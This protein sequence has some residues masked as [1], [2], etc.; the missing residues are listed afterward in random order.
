[1]GDSIFLRG[2]E[3][4][5]AFLINKW[6]NDSEIQKLV[7]TS[8]KYVSLEIE[9]EWVKSKMMD[10]RKDIYL[11]ICLND[12][13]RKIVGYVSVN[14]IDYVNRTAD[15]GGIVIGD[16]QY[17]DG[18]IKYEVGVKI[19]ELVFDHL[20]MN[21]FTGACL[22]EHKISRI[23]MEACG[24]KLEGIR[25]QAIYKNGTYH[26]QLCYSLLREEYY[27]LLNDGQYTFMAFAKRVK[28]IRK[29]LTR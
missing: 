24:Y 25:R 13:S 8:F 22:L 1:M 29:D 3:I 16:K 28:Q 20:N 11:A 10:N 15:G 2:F 17:Q 5:D 14:N 18:E 23:M 9:K 6:R 21:R 26:D 4:E 7:S 19:R 12:V 27:R